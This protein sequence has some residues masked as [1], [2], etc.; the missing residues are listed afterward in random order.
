MLVLPEYFIDKLP[1][2]SIFIDMLCLNI[3]LFIAE[4]KEDDIFT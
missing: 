1:C 3:A 2:K 4:Y